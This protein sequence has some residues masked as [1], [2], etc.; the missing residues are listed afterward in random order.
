[1]GH[2]VNFAEILMQIGCITWAMLLCADPRKR[3]L[4]ISL[5]IAFGALTAALFLTETRAALGGLAAGCFV[6]VLILAAR[7]TRIWAIAVLVVLVLASAL[8]IHHTRG[9][10]WLGAHDPGTHFR[11]MMWEDGLRLIGQHPWFGVGMETVRNHWKE[12][13]IRAFTFF[14]DESHFHSDLM[15]IAVERGL[16]TLAAWLWFIVAYVIFLLRLIGKARQRSRFAT[17]VA[18]GVLAS[19]VA[20]QTTAL[21]HYDLGIESVAMILFFYFGLAIATDRI[22][23]QPK[24]VDVP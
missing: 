15:Q 13:N 11:T 2:Y 6:A 4:R 20:F 18:A 8:W 22:L 23:G 19:F 16:L 3:T 12:W 9:A 21:V 7:R 14:H 24:A 10:Q 5:A 1:M 17:G